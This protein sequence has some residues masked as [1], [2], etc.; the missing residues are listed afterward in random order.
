MSA[1]Y[2]APATKFVSGHGL[3]YGLGYGATKVVSSAPVYSAGY[4]APALAAHGAVHG[5][6]GL[7]YGLGASK[8]KISSKFIS[9]LPLSIFCLYYFRSY[10]LPQ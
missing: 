9:V 2:A 7:G 4:A 8:V 10:L 3:G 1:S 6:Y 5:A